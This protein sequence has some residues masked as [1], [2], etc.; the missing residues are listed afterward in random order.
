MIKITL[1]S[2]LLQRHRLAVDVERALRKSGRITYQQGSMY[3]HYLTG[4]W[5]NRVTRESDPTRYS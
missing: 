1:P 2:N 3:H 4:V 5:F